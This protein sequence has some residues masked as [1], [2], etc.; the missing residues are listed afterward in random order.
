[1]FFVLQ[2]RCKYVSNHQKNASKIGTAFITFVVWGCFRNTTT[3]KGVK[4]AFKR[5]LNCLQ[6]LFIMV[7]LGVFSQIKYFGNF[8]K[9]IASRPCNP[10]VSRHFPHYPGISRPFPSI[11]KSTACLQKR[12]SFD[13][14]H[15]NSNG[16]G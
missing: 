6:R 3:G 16:L 4:M 2:T 5:G 13:G 11:R 10:F 8:K 12:H 15:M 14:G 9:K 7:Y 1:M